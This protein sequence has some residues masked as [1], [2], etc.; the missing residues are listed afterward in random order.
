MYFLHPNEAIVD[1]IISYFEPRIFSVNELIWKQGSCSA[2]AILIMKGNVISE[3]EDEAGTKTVLGIGYLLGE[4]G[5]VNR[6]VSYLLIQL[7]INIKCLLQF[8]H[9]YAFV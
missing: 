9:Y 2:S 5:L 1:R 4:Y 6:R 7:I 3:L 8:Y